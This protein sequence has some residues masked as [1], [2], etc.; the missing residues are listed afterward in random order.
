MIKNLRDTFRCIG[1]DYPGFGLSKASNG[2]IHTLKEHSEIFRLFIETLDLYEVTM[3]VHDIGGPIG[4]KVAGIQPERF[5]ALVIA[6]TFAW[7]LKDYNSQ[8][9]ELMVKMMGSP[10]GSLI[11][12]S[13]L[14]LRASLKIK[15]SSLSQEEKAAY[16]GPFAKLSKRHPI[17]NL[18]RS[19]AQ[20]EGYLTEVKQGLGDLRDLSVLLIFGDMDPIFEAGFMNRF[21]RI[22][23]R[24]S[25]VVIKGAAHFSLEE[26][27][28][29]IVKAIRNWWKNE[30]DQKGESET[31]LATKK[32]RY[33]VV[34]YMYNV[35]SNC[36]FPV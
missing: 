22:F 25:S 12:D 23:P 10:I 24:S 18:F 32:V 16:L 36:L 20:S 13:N 9:L 33:D 1:L 7:P 31:Y 35:I 26:A 17:H 28:E 11:V 29:E 19:I 14:L 5:R 21:E 6:D 30:V 8:K 15:R 2:F 27:P 4:L 3:M 34:L